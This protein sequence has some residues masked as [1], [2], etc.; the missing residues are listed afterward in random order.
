M[1]NVV[2]VSEDSIAVSYKAKHF[3]AYD[4]AVVLLSIY[5]NEI[6]FKSI[7]QKPAHEC[8]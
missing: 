6:F 1:Q 7:T 5:P 8:L 2:A 4:L 3:L